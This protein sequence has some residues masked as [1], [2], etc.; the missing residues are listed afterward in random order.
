MKKIFW[1]S[2]AVL[3]ISACASRPQWVTNPPNDKEFI[4]GLG[5]AQN[6]NEA[7]AWQAA[8]NRARQGLSLQINAILEIMQNDYG[9]AEG[10]SSSADFFQTVS[11]EMSSAVLHG[12]EVVKRGTG[13]R[14]RYYVLACYKKADMRQ[15]V[16]DSARREA[17][18]NTAFQMERALETMDRE[19]A[20]SRSVPIR[21]RD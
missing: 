20:K 3:C 18:G 4:Y 7:R 13:S 1:I 2:L 19:F 12:A 15:A 6:N 21:D 16:A 8:E 11:R 9:K 17:A 5:V 10:T 14:N